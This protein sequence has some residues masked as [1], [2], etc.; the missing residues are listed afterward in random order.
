MKG[1]LLKRYKR[2]L[3]DIRT[4]DGK[5]ITAYC[6]ATGRMTSCLREGARVEYLPVNDPDRK[7]DYDWWSIQMPDSW[8]IIDTRP[9]N[10]WLFWNRT[11]S[12]LPDSWN[13]ASWV[14]EPATPRGG[15]FDF[16]LKHPEGPDTWLEIKSVTWCEDGTGYFPDAPTKRGREHLEKLIQFQGNG[17]NS[18]I[19]F[20]SMRSDINEI[21]PAGTVDPEFSKLL[22][23]ADQQGV[24][25][26]GIDS[27]VDDRSLTM[28]GRVPVILN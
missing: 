4:E 27:Y 21:L 10:K 28:I 1:Y 22:S 23:D 3:A 11:A 6:P 2:F 24:D 15:R 13:R 14:A 26:I 12:W 7:L 9:A 19:V 17:Y 5:E 16:R 20:V 18:A 25:I 8:V